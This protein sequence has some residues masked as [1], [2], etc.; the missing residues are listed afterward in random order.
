M[1]S[2]EPFQM[3]LESCQKKAF[4]NN[5]P[6][7]PKLPVVDHL[8][9]DRVVVPCVSVYP[10]KLCFW[11]R[12]NRNYDT[13]F[14]L[15]KIEG[16]KVDG[17]L[18]AKANKRIKTAVDWLLHLSPVK[19]LYIEKA[20]KEVDFRINFITL[21]LPAPQ[22]R[23]YILP[24]GKRFESYDLKKFFPAANLNFGKLEYYPQ[25]L[26]SGQ[27][28]AGD[29]LFIKSYLLNQFLIEIKSK[30]NC[31]DYVWKAETQDN[32]SIHF[33]ISL[34]RYIFHS[35][36]RNLWNRILQKSDFI[37][38]YKQK[39]LGMSETDYVQEYFKKGSVSKNI[40]IERYWKG[41]NSEWISPNT[42]DVHA[43]H[44]IRNIAAYLCKYLTKVDES[45]RH[46]QGYLWRLS[47]SLSALKSF[48]LEVTGNLSE[49][50]RWLVEKFPKNRFR[51]DWI[52]VFHMDIVQL[53]QLIPGSELV[54]EFFKYKSEKLL[55][56]E[57]QL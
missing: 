21:T 32:G 31:R 3:I 4:I 46:V 12:F 7:P 33:H 28:V 13:N 38:R 15:K 35:D 37:S 16:L 1:F 17:E 43:V 45:R 54:R 9:D 44:N 51:H 25:V 55:E 39:H 40:L 11:D 53:S 42:T 34:N 29:D 18:S 23:A 10:S 57:I 36:L 26:S 48:Y 41:R 2:S 20:R 8:P 22:V 52:D 14:D 27:I 50:L 49:E 19:K 6:A 30:Y 5:V 24:C 47:A 56:P